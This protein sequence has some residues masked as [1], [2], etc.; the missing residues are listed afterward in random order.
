[1][2]A[3]ILIGINMNLP[4]SLGVISVHFM[5]DYSSFSQ[6]HPLILLE[7]CC[8]VVFQGHSL[9]SLGAFQRSLPPSEH[10]KMIGVAG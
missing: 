9:M 10:R 1:M 8:Q 2:P 6:A 3:G 4:G 5:T 7:I